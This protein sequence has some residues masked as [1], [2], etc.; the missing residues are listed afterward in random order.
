VPRRRSDGLGPGLGQ[1]I[2]ALRRARGETLASLAARSGL[3]VT[4]LSQLETGAED[5]PTIGVLRALAGGLEVPLARLLPDLAGN[6]AE[7]LTPA[8]RR[9]NRLLADPSLPAPVKRL[10]EATIDTW[11]T[12]ASNA[13]AAPGVSPPDL[14]TLFGRAPLETWL[15]DRALDPDARSALMRS[16]SASVVQSTPSATER[17]DS[18][19]ESTR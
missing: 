7:P 17:N 19:T 10:V 15:L 8:A 9:L 4:Y 11:V 3:S 18:D 5:N 6:G 13:P 1:E 2:R 16:V 12:A 14:L